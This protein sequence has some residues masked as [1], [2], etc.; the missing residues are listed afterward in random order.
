MNPSTHA[1]VRHDASEAQNS[2]VPGDRGLRENEDLLDVAHTELLV[3]K[4]RNHSQ[5]SLIFESTEET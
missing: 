3:R 1:P 4:E 5:S 2:Q